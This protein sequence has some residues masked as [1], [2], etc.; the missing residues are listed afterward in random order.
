MKVLVLSKL[1]E[2]LSL[3]SGKL[4]EK[5]MMV[6]HA[7]LRWRSRCP[8]RPLVEPRNA[9]ISLEIPNQ[10]YCQCELIIPTRLGGF[11]ARRGNKLK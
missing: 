1:R 8:Y 2:S 11:L 6:R 9:G 7:G 10:P 3:L 4:I 5:S